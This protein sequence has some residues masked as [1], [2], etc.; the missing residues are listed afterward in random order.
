MATQLYEFER[1]AL[2]PIAHRILGSGVKRLKHVG[3]YNCRGL[4]QFKNILSQ[5]AFANAIDVSGFVLEYGQSISVE[6]DWK[7]SDPKSQFLR[8]VSSAACD[9][10]H[11]TVSPGDDV[12]HWNHL[13]WDM[14]LYRNCW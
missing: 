5:H 11:V 7:R 8:E 10:F 6:A 3:T 9:A 4:R 13:H 1:S 14:G 2:Q 12:N